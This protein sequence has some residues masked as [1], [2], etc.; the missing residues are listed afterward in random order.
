MS[1]QKRPHHCA[2][3]PPHTHARTPPHTDL[4]ADADAREASG[5]R[6]RP[7][8]PPV[9]RP[10]PLQKC[11]QAKRP[12]GLQPPAPPPARPRLHAPRATAPPAPSPL[13]A[14]PTSPTHGMH[15]QTR[16]SQLS[17]QTARGA[18][19]P[20]VAQRHPA[21]R[22]APQPK[23]FAQPKANVRPNPSVQMK[24]CG[25]PHQTCGVARPAPPHVRAPAPFAGR[26]GVA[27]AQLKR[28]AGFPPPRAAVAPAR[29]VIQRL[30]DEDFGHGGES[31]KEEFEACKAFARRVSAFVDQAYEE[32]T[33]GN[34]KEWTGSKIATFLEMV[35]N[36]HKSAKTHAANAI[37]ER[38]YALMK[39]TDMGLKWVPQYA[40]AM[41]GVSKPD[42]VIH[43]PSRK[44]ALIDITSERGHILRKS[45]GWTTNP[46]YIYVAEAFFRPIR[47]HH[48][49][50]IK[51][52]I[53]EGGVTVQQ[54]RKLRRQ[55]DL[56]KLAERQVKIG[57]R[58]SV[59]EVLNSY[60]SFSKYAMAEFSSLP[61]GSRLTAATK[62]LRTHGITVKGMRQLKGRRKASEETRRKRTVLARKVRAA[63]ERESAEELL[64]KIQA[65]KLTTSMK[66]ST[67]RS[68]TATTSRPVV[69][70]SFLK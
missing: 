56:V 22:L 4:R 21:A 63:K 46:A 31:T 39:A 37:E 70:R 30:L 12:A 15:A 11:L 45:G 2:S 43:L 28:Q 26:A 40:E 14:K 44:C 10:Q 66:R 69:I 23:L 27:A 16:A 36:D 41:G 51:A 49:S 65:P 60:P 7:A 54:A 19:T 25:V 32:L 6:A 18:H 47:A 17:A 68:A 13:R 3:H 33:T 38:V 58:D 24:A 1:Q 34:V 59:R 57:L 5:G 67:R 35:L 29:G 53:E 52:A 55:A 48:M 9:Y 42:I 61:K 20:Q 50:G 62:H 64:Q 8:P